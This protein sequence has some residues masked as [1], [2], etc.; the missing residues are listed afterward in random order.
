MLAALLGRRSLPGA[1]PLA[2]AHFVGASVIVDQLD[3]GI[4][5]RLA[6]FHALIQRDALGEDK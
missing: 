5:A 4:R 1:R 6:K 3:P 2:D